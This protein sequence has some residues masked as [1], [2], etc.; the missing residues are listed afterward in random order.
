MESTINL[1]FSGNGSGPKRMN[2]CGAWSGARDRCLHCKATA[3]KF[4]KRKENGLTVEES[5]VIIPDC[6]GV[7][8]KFVIF[9][10]KESLPCRKN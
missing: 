9:T 7:P 2:C 4:E 6:V 5:C 1:L 10:K 8:D 3:A